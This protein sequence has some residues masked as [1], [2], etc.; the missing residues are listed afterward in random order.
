MK[1]KDRHNTAPSPARSTQKT[2][3]WIDISN[4]DLQARLLLSTRKKSKIV[5]TQRWGSIR[6][7]QSNIEAFIGRKNHA[8][9]FLNVFLPLCAIYSHF[10]TIWTLSEPGNIS[11]NI[12]NFPIMEAIFESQITVGNTISKSRNNVTPVLHCLL[13]IFSIF[14]IFLDRKKQLECHFWHRTFKMKLRISMDGGIRGKI[15]GFSN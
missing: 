8:Q 15:D 10:V 5:K 12:R 9:T 6:L 11:Q 14:R 3:I 4:S 2:N 1:E 7:G 13:I